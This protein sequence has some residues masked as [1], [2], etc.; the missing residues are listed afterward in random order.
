MP[1]S[2]AIFRSCSQARAGDQKGEPDHQEE[3]GHD[4][5]DLNVGKPH[6]E[7][8][9]LEQRVAAVDQRR[10]R[11]Y[12]RTLG[13]LDVVLQHDRYADGGNERRQ[14]ERV[15]QRPVGDALDGPSI[16]RGE[17]HGDDEHDE[18]RQRHRGYA[19]G[20]QHQEGNQ[21]DERPDHEDVAVGEVDHADDAVDHRVADGDQAVDRTE[22]DAVDELLDEVFHASPSALSATS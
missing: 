18:Q 10:Q 7:V 15:A 21:R 19:D 20:D 16:E 1:R 22:R 9:A 6:G 5:D 2:A 11:L 3:R 17:R 14:A 12:P 13:D 4:H 8:V